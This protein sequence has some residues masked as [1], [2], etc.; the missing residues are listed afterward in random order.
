MSAP[1]AIQA[2][3]DFV[4][5]FL[6]FLRFQVL[7]QDLN[8]A[9]HRGKR[10]LDLMRQHGGQFAD[11]DEA[12]LFPQSHLETHSFGQIAN[13][14]REL[15]LTFEGQLRHRQVGR[16][17]G[18]VLAASGHLAANADNPAFTGHLIAPQVVVVLGRVR[19]RHEHRDVVP[20]NVLSAVAEHAFGRGI[21]ELDPPVAI[22]HDDG[23][24][25]RFD[26]GA[27]PC[28][29]SPLGLLGAPLDA[30]VSR[31]RHGPDRLSRRV[32]N[33]CD[34]HG[35]VDA[36]AIPGEPDGIVRFNTLSGSQHPQDLVLLA[37][38]VGRQEDGERLADDV[39]G[40]IAEDAFGPPIPR[41]HGPSEVVRHDG[42]IGGLHDRDQHSL[43]FIIRKVGLLHV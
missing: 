31:D 6:V 1:S 34:R 14:A 17:H 42:V 38:V 25:G 39:G 18:A 29:A 19:L 10:V 28:L 12:R 20:E 21:E 30:D 37:V 16:K 40:G 11:S 23:V 32:A 3:Q 27:P 8:G 22:D 36:I 33:S 4:H 26:D 35:D 9:A 24:D 2:P 13:D 43:R 41:E 5:D 7:A 15:R